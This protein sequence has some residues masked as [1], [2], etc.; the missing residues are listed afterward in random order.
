MIF[1]FWGA[2]AVAEFSHQHKVPLTIPY[3]QKQILPSITKQNQ[4]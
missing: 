4:E 3:K 1:L 2:K